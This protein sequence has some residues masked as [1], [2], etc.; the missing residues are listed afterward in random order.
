MIINLSQVITQI[1]FFFG[2]W[3]YI[4]EYRIIGLVQDMGYNDM[5][6]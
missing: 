4:E 1:H 2:V 3:E 5:G 6:S